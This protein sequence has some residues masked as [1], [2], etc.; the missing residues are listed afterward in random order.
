MCKRP[1]AN[2]AAAAVAALCRVVKDQAVALRQPR[3]CI[4]PLTMALRKLQPGPEYL[5][6]IHAD[7]CQAC[8]P[9]PLLPALECRSHPHANVHTYSRTHTHTHMRT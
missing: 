4:F 1:T 2:G 9:C 5:T 8:V 6:P 7:L 3:R